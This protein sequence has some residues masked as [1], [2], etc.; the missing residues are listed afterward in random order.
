M[1]GN[2]KLRGSRITPLKER[3]FPGRKRFLAATPSFFRKYS[4]VL[5]PCYKFIK[6]NFS[7][8]KK[9]ETLSS[10]GFTFSKDRT[11]SEGGFAN[12]LCLRVVDGN[13]TFFIKIGRQAS[14]EFLIAY[15]LA[16]KLLDSKGGKL[17]GYNVRL[18]KSH[19]VFNS[20]FEGRLSSLGSMSSNGVLVSDF[21]PSSKGVLVYDLADSV[22]KKGINWERTEFGRAVDKIKSFFE[23]RGIHDVCSLNMF[24][25]S[26]SKTIYLFD[27]HVYPGDST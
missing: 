26:H 9:G 1:H 12:A 23:K 18:V 8:L 24:F 3:V 10:H 27:F 11:G 4:S 21:F 5:L 14:E 16:K 19:F 13:K 20:N 7:R 17:F 2:K 22:R 15:N 6:A 25:D